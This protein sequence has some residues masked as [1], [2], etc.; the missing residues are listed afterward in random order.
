[1]PRCPHCHYILALLEERHKYK[2]S[3]CSKLFPQ[4]AIELQEFRKW[5][6]W[7]RKLDR[8]TLLEQARERKI[9]L[10]ERKA[11]YA[12]RFLFKERKQRKL[13]TAKEQ[14][15]RRREMKQQWRLNNPEKVRLMNQKWVE[16][17]KDRRYSY[18][19]QWRKSKDYEA[20]LK[21]RLAYWR[22]QQKSLALLNLKND[23]HWAYTDETFRSPPTLL[24]CHLLLTPECL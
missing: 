20:R 10:Q 13:M 21:Q 17:N 15:Q 18:L 19:K 4:K 14:R 22:A 1:M 9:T 12:F 7:Q 5:N 16:K 11:L 24:P 23:G 6:E 2:C 3:K 8:K